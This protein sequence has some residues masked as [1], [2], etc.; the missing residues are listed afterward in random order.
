MHPQTNK[1][2]EVL[3]K[4]QFLCSNSSQ[5]EQR[6]LYSIIEEDPEKFY[7]YFRPLGFELERGEEF[8]YF[9]RKEARADLERKIEQAYKW[10]DIL[11]F[12]KT[13]NNSFGVGFRFMPSEILVQIKIDANLKDK[14]DQLNK[15]LGDG[16]HKDRVQRLI[17]ELVKYGFLELEGEIMQQYKVLSSYAYIEKLL[18][19]IQ[20][21]EEEADEVSK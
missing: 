16:S 20:I 11:D 17:D 3:S 9:S 21:T 14:I 8:F 10:I 6:R 12:F 5:E 18:V 13:Y 15:P 19:S 4:G 7:D 2:F 1:I